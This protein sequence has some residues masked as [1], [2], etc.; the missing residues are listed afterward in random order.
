M[1][2]ELIMWG[3]VFIFSLL[4]ILK[5]STYFLNSLQK[6]GKTLK[7][8]TFVLGIIVIA[9]GSSF[10]ELIVSISSVLQESSEIVMTTVIGSNITN[11]FL[12]FGIALIFIKKIKINRQLIN[13]DL[14]LLIGSSFLMFVLIWDG[15]FTWIESLFCLAGLIVFGAYLFQIQQKKIAFSK[16]KEV[17]K[18]NKTQ[19]RRLFLK[20]CFIFIISFAF[21]YISAQYI[22]ISTVEL[23]S[24]LN[25]GVDIISLGAI[26]LGTSLLELIIVIKMARAKEI[27]MIIGIIIGSNIFNIFAV[28]GISSLFGVLVVSQEAILFLPLMLIA[29]FLFFFITQD[30]QVTQ[31]E[32]WIFIIFYLFFITHLIGLL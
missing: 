14:P 4:I 25:I 30:R 10:P 19:N 27:E 9:I 5:S 8:P 23:S 7:I 18:Q 31:W 13:I 22:V 24:M 16:N 6:I 21:L 3:L 15:V 1:L 29:A 32:G 17:N 28:I 20:N 2:Q 11:I 12:V 26:A